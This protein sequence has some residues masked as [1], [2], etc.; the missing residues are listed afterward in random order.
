VQ[1]EE[2]CVRRA[3]EKHFGLC[4]DRANERGQAN[5]CGAKRIARTASERRVKRGKGNVESIQVKENGDI[6]FEEDKAVRTYSRVRVRSDL[7]RIC[8]YPFP[9]LCLFPNHALCP[10]HDPSSSV[11]PG[12]TV[13]PRISVGARESV[14]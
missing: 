10:F 8:L 7:D 6:P 2:I 14:S 13:D 4:L 9:F 11:G 3:G 12:Q 5:V 1:V